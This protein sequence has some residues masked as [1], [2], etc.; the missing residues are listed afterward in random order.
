M[1]VQGQLPADSEHFA[2]G[3]QG[4]V[5]ESHGVMAHA[6]VGTTD[7]ATSVQVRNRLKQVGGDL[8]LSGAEEC[9]HC[10]ATSVR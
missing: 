3:L 10:S 5:L 4:L 1:E 7:V 6:L 8:L 2:S 9:V